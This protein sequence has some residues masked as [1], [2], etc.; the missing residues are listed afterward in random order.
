VII[1]P[2]C[3]LDRPFRRQAPA[4]DF[5][6]ILQSELPVCYL[7]EEEVHISSGMPSVV[8]PNTRVEPTR[9]RLRLGVPSLACADAPARSARLTHNRWAGDDYIEITSLDILVGQHYPW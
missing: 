5:I 9:L 4:E 6:S 7:K 2:E 1:T 8:Q 3:G